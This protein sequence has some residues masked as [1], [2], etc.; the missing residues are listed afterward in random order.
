MFF[1]N[2]ITK[3]LFL[4]ILGK[5]LGLSAMERDT[6]DQAVEATPSIQ[7]VFG[8]RLRLKNCTDA[9][10]EVDVKKIDGSCWSAI[11]EDDNSMDLGSIHDNFIRITITPYQT[12]NR[13]IDIP[14]EQI[15]QF[16]NISK[17]EMLY[18]V[19]EENKGVYNCHFKSIICEKNPLPNFIN[20]TSQGI[21]EHPAYRAFPAFKN[22]LIRMLVREINME[23]FQKLDPVKFHQC[24]LGIDSVFT[25]EDVQNRAD[26]LIQEWNPIFYI[27]DGTSEIVEKIQE[28][29]KSANF[30]L[31]NCLYG[32]PIQD[33]VCLQKAAASAFIQPAYPHT[34]EPEEEASTSQA[35][36]YYRRPDTHE[37]TQ[38]KYAPVDYFHIF[39][40][41]VKDKIYSYEEQKK[42]NSTANQ[43]LLDV[44]EAE[45][46]TISA[47]ELYELINK[48][49]QKYDEQIKIRVDD[50]NTYIHKQVITPGSEI[51]IVGD[52]HGSIHS[53]VKILDIMLSKIKPNTNFVFLGD[54][55]DRGL[56]GAEVL[57][58]L[59]CLK[60]TSWDKVF[61]IRGNHE[62]YEM[63]LHGGWGQDEYG[64]FIGA[65]KTE[66][67]AKYG[68]ENGN[69]LLS[70]FKELYNRLPIAVYLGTNQETWV[71]FC[72][73]GFQPDFNPNVF[74]SNSE[75]IHKIE[76]GESKFN[77]ETNGFVWGDFYL[78][79]NQIIQD[80]SGRGQ[81]LNFIK[82]I[83]NVMSSSPS[84]Q[85]PECTGVKAIFRGHQHTGCG[86]K[87]FP[88]IT[89]E[90]MHK[91]E[92]TS[93]LGLEPIPWNEVVMNDQDGLVY[94]T[95]ENRGGLLSTICKIRIGYY[96]PI[97]TFSTA[98]E[99]G[100][101]NETF[102]GILQ[103]ADNFSDWL[104][105]P[106]SIE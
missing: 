49:I 104:L 61:L 27:Q 36:E 23:S 69:L 32:P 16:Q 82:N 103:T 84:I 11:V 62:S 9:Q 80:V 26:R 55:S 71:Q 46:P 51:N 47:E 30:F 13:T 57:I 5:S 70:Q 21:G 101:T 64:T 44:F 54:Y 17:N 89:D 63:N 50:H 56:F 18:Y 8:H 85:A 59:M 92:N 29:I 7:S 33:K 28:Y 40:N 45:D 76:F 73:G 99:H 106:I 3:L 94:E 10:L 48:C 78:K 37:A 24:V 1:K 6:Q 77:S 31:I 25:S 90:S 79:N 19:V 60:L 72:H 38:Q 2:F 67:E 105:Q 39:L 66:L 81:S 20:L 14:L 4:F 88:R 35:T 74:L 22:E 93:G 52:I 102:Y 42:Y 34:Y 12:T 65:F 86:L 43:L 68:S 98:T 96:I 87:M 97:F 100:L 91:Y 95:I 83:P 15:K 53:L 41:R 75:N 58:L